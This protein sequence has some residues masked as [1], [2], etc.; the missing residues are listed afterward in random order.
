[1]TLFVGAAMVSVPTATEGGRQIQAFYAA[2]ATVILIQQILGIVALGFL[3]AFAVAIGARQRRFLLAGTV[4]LAVTELATNIPPAILSLTDLGPDG[5][6]ALTVVEDV[7]DGALFISIAV[8][9]VAATVDQVWWVRAAGWLVAALA[10]LRV[11]MT[12]FDVRALD[13]LAP[14]ALLA[15]VLILSVRLLMGRSTP[16]SIRAA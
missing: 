15:L 2:H 14:T 5:A 12:L 9:V 10:L 6:H 8:F 4:L 16:S 3:L 13:V 11:V 1:V 7:A